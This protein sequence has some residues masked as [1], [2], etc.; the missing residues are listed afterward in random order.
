MIT[1]ITI[2]GKRVKNPVAKILITLLVLPFITLILLF[3]FGLIVPFI[4]VVIVP[5]VFII[6]GLAIG[7]SLLFPNKNK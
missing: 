4:F 1:M 7:I 2:N 6:A 5:A 3:I